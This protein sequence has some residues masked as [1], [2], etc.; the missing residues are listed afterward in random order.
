MTQG[1]ALPHYNEV[2]GGL[3]SPQRYNNTNLLAAN[4]AE[5]IPVP[6]DLDGNLAKWVTF[7]KTSA[8]AVDFYAKPML[9]PDGNELSYNGTFAEFV[10]NGAFASDT[11]WTKGTGWSIAGGVAAIASTHI[12]VSDLTQTAA[13]T[14]VSGDIYTL[15]I[16]T[17]L[18]SHV[19]NGTFASDTG[20]TKGSGWTI[21]GGAANATTASS[22]ISQ[23]CPQ[24]LVAGRTYTVVFDA[25]RSAG[26]VAVSLGGGTPGTSRSTSATFTEVITAGAAQD[27]T[28]TGVGF[29]GTLDNVT[30]TAVGNI[31]VSLGGGTAGTAISTATTTIQQITAGATQAITIEADANFV[32]TVDNVTVSGWT[33]GTGWTTDGATAIATGAINTTI[34]QAAQ[35]P[36]L[37]SGQTYLVTF[38][39]TRAAGSIAV[40]LGGGTPGTSRSSAATFSEV[41]TAGS[42]QDIT[43][44]GTGF[45]GTL[46]NVTVKKCIAVPG[47]V[48]DGSSP[49]LNPPG[50]LLNKNCT[51]I[52]I[53]SAGAPI[54][55]SSFYK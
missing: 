23:T 3:Q 49:D 6:Y 10:T 35:T 22:T 45:T 43:F 9:G 7:S 50:F 52:S 37:V 11:G 41:I 2:P 4:I 29:S 1:V 46:D 53:V 54:V 5:I 8:T 19:T 31:S 13:Q 20:W 42:A 12:A 27:V 28:F 24:T 17:A 33:L 18:T 44:T 47:D 39:A 38:T 25:T 55:V 51:S 48:T 36:G 14:L 15:T 32:G 21:S 40:S 16:T 30:I 26:S 34:T